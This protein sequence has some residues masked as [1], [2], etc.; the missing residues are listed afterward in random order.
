MCLCKC[1]CL[2]ALAC[3]CVPAMARGLKPA[4]DDFALADRWIGD[5][6]APAKQAVRASRGAAKAAPP[7]LTVVYNH[8][9]VQ[10][11]ARAGE[12]LKIGDAVY[13][14][15]LYCHAPS[16]VIVRLPGPGRS[17]SAQVGV[18]SRAGG[19][20]VVFSVNAAGAK[21][22][23][24][25]VMHGGEAA[26]PVN[27]D[28]KRAVEFTLEVGD[29]GDGIA[30]DQA[31]WAEAK[32]T[33]ADGREVL[34]G[35]LPIVETEL[36]RRVAWSLPFSFSY[37][38]KSSD[39]LLGAWKFSRTTK[40]LDRNRTQTTQT[41]T[42]PATGLQLKCVI[43]KYT[44]FPTVEWTL[45]FTNTGRTDTPILADILALD[46]KLSRGR[47]GEF[48][49][50][51][52]KGDSCTPDSYQPLD[53]TLGPNARK[54]IAPAGGRPTSG[55]FPYFNIGQPGGGVIAVVSWAGQWSAS[56][57]RDD[58]AGLRVTAG[59]ELTH[60]KLHPG[61]SART[62]MIV[63]QFYTGDTLRGQNIWRRWMLAHNMPKGAK[64][65]C[66]TCIGGF[67][68]GIMC[69]EADGKQFCDRFLAEG[70]KVDYWW[71]DAGWYPCDPAIG[72]PQTGTWEPDP[73]RYPNGVRA[74]SDYVHARGMKHVLWFEPERVHAGTWLAQ[75]HPEWIHGGANGGLLRLDNS[76]CLKWVIEH[77]DKLITEQ[78][79]D[80]YRQDFNIDPLSY[81]RADEPED[82]QG[83][84]ENHHITAY[85]AY[86]DELRRR[87][88][89]MLI[90]S[91][92]S[93]G[94]RN[95]LETLR[96]A[97][98]LLR[99]DYQCE[100]VGNQAHTYGLSS[101]LPYYGTGVYQDSLYNHHSSIAPA[102]G[103]CG[104][105]RKPGIDYAMLR[106]TKSDWRAVADLMLGDYYP[107]TE[108]SIDKG[109]WIAFQ[110]DR[111]D[112]G[113][114]M[115]QAFR[116]QESKDE[117]IPVK[118]HGLD[119]KAVYALVD[120]CSDFKARFTGRELMEGGLSITVPKAP[121]DALI[122]YQREEASK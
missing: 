61:E 120:R 101:W 67:F 76:D 78:G 85:F 30:C 97:V 111:P 2:V 35:D 112:M 83:I 27:V 44:D 15:G 22:F 82:R 80:L 92:A 119:P 71:T 3:L 117:S 12:P 31:N 29:A 45:H 96:R 66:S 53:E 26:A 89:G 50:H 121:G 5:H 49:L 47:T 65:F 7:G 56:F 87:H 55:E 106:Q 18:D 6:F 11:N 108:W 68:P 73:K 94:R 46:T 39:E 20:S 81:W 75:Q 33:L 99:S 52:I 34:L 118:L 107:L 77:F 9:D 32:A 93:G 74:L 104:D 42:D 79:I 84:T 13:K 36:P 114:G 28:L 19:G 16:K 38:P 21:L 62:P 24:S 100:P 115:L 41:Y 88:P 43:V 64:P 4:K 37:G 90:D 63:L 102:Y 10:R 110:F 69:S 51:R 48:V 70:F 122:V 86:W 40:K 14:G 17:F 57:A 105:V 58:K 54:R 60:F 8:G 116:R 103:I 91:C 95:D 98:P 113:K 1:L 72:W 109:K 25:G 23:G 59:Q